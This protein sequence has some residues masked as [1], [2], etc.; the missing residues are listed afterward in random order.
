M[1]RA[2][3]RVLETGLRKLLT[4]TKAET[5]DTDKEPPSDHRASARPYQVVSAEVNATEAHHE[6]YSNNRGADH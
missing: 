3:W 6:D 4:G 2:M 5:P 1:L